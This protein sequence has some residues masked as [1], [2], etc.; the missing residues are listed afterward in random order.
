MS[1]R[2]SKAQ[3]GIL[4]YNSVTRYCI[5]MSHLV[6]TT[7]KAAESDACQEVINTSNSNIDQA[8]RP[9]VYLFASKAGAAASVTSA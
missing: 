3:C 9:T 8:E 2:A 7:S 5:R 6:D 1:Y 4:P